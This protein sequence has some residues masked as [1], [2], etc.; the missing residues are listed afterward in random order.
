MSNPAKGKASNSK[1]V[2]D[3]VGSSKVQAFEARGTPPSKRRL[4]LFRLTA[5]SIPLVLILLIEIAFRVIPG[6]S[7]DQDPYVNIS[8]VSVFSRKIIDGKEYYYITH[9]WVLGN[10]SLQIAVKKPANTIRIFFLGSS[11][12][13]GWPHPS[14]ETVSAYLQQALEAAYPK[15]KI[16]VINA[17]A[18]GFAA[19][20]TRLVLDEVLQMGPDAVVV[21]EGNN[22]FLEDRNYDSPS[23]LFVNLG[24]H[25]RIVQ[26]LRSIA[27]SRT[28]MSGEDLKD[29][30]EF[31]W[32]KTRQQSLRLR[33][34]PV[35]FVQ[36]QEHFRKSFEHMV[37]QSQHYEV[38]IVVCTVPVNLRDW[39]PTVSVNHLKGQQ[40]QQWQK[41]YNLARRCLLEGRYKEGI[42]AMHRAIAMEAAHGESYF[43]LGRLLEGDGQKA[44]AWE[45][46]SKARDND[47][48]PFRAISSFNETIRALAKENQ[49]KGVSML[50]LERLFSGATKYAAPGFDLFLDYVHPTKP[51]NLMVAENLYN[52]MMNHGMLKG[53]SAVDRF[54]YYDLLAASNGKP[55]RDEM[56]ARLQ[57][58]AISMAIENRQYETIINKL[59]FMLEQKTGQRPTGP[60]DL[61][62]NYLTPQFADGYR[63]FHNYLDVE[64]RVIL[65]LPL[66]ESDQEDAKQQIAKF[67]EKWFPLGVF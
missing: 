59:E 26:R 54:T 31:F 67:Y 28:E 22:E 14:D 62:L 38:P 10:H 63:V 8:P 55:Y 57:N 35:Q 1:K 15:K 7:E 41:Q 2:K 17:S 50:D 18:H 5:I 45:A 23:A 16:E 47:Y 37:S 20:R 40:L 51:A 39:V 21:W 30:A 12:C 11:A 36:V 4:W 44:S 64:R 48:N 66:N 61:M 58:T 32:K 29:V 3:A 49:S 56:D 13:A 9:R 33:E 24:R 53:K 6:L 52:L 46:F 60:D 65:G 34:D 25:L 19:Y 42:E 43:W 27:A